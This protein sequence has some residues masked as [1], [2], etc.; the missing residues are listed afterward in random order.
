MG[1]RDSSLKGVSVGGRPLDDPLQLTYVGTRV[2][3]EDREDVTERPQLA[4]QIVRAENYR[5]GDLCSA[6]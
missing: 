1:G 3:K 5:Q 2:A 6:V 4:T